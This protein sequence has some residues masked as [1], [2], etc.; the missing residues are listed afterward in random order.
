MST[1]RLPLLLI[2]ALLAG[3]GEVVIFGHT[4]REGNASSESK[5]ESKEPASSNVAPEYHAVKVKTVTLALTQPAEEKAASDS[6]FDKDALLGAIKDELRSRQVL[7]E[8]DAGAGMVEISID[9]FA[10]QPTTNAIVFGRI[11]SEGTLTGTVRLRNAAG[12]TAQSFHIDAQT[13][14]S[15]DASGE[16]PNPLGPLYHRFAVLTA[17][18]LTDTPSKPEPTDQ[19]PR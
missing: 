6:K 1:I 18:R 4:V 8:T 7:D 11:Y 10:V 2:F 17:D 12:D 3:C 14:F 5:A 9:N 15:I 19:P 13:R 16:E